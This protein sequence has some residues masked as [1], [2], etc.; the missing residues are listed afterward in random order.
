MGVRLGRVAW[1]CPA[2][3]LLLLQLA[4]ASHVVYETSLLET[5]AAAATVPP[6]IF[7]LSTGYHFRPQKNWI[8]GILICQS[9][10]QHPSLY[11]SIFFELASLYAR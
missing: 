10:N 1:A 5:E 9:V 2:V 8:N 11:C 7:E 6:S 3:L 4:G